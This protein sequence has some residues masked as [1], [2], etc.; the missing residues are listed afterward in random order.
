[1]DFYINGNLAM[2]FG[3]R[4]AMV[5][6]VIYDDISHQDEDD[7]PKISGRH[8]CRM[9]RRML[10][11]R[12][13]MLT[14]DNARR[15]LKHLVDEGIIIKSEHNGSRFDRTASYTFTEFGRTVM[16]HAYAGR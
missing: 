11:A 2:R 12:L 8:W 13:P 5:L 4:E 16:E 6:D 1:M 15:T 7:D 3:I 9:S 10:T 14:E